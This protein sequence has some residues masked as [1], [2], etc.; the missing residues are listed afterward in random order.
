MRL[1]RLRFTV[2]RLMLAVALVGVGV[3]TVK[4][5]RLSR[6]YGSKAQ[7]SHYLEALYGRPG[8]I[9]LRNIQQNQELLATS[10]TIDASAD[11]PTQ[12]FTKHRQWW[13]AKSRADAARYATMT[14]H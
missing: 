3:W 4:M 14:I 9:R 10:D 5:W 7:H 11:V 13:A 8:A 12:E 6:E 2:R 1:P